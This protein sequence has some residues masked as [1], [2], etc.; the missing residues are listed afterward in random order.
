MLLVSISLFVQYTLYLQYTL[1]Q[2]SHSATST[3]SASRAVQLPRSFCRAF[4]HLWGLSVSFHLGFALTC[5]WRIVPSLPPILLRR[6]HRQELDPQELRP[7]VTIQ[8]NSLAQT[9]HNPSLQTYLINTIQAT[10]K[11]QH[12]CP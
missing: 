7:E 11:Y 2:P 8:T 12:I 5:H 10:Q 9:K 3:Y 1:A 4:V 6:P